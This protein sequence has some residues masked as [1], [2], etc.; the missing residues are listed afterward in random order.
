M[1]VVCLSLATQLIA[2]PT[3]P[4]ALAA[5]DYP[6]NATAR[7]HWTPQFGS[8]PVNVETQPDGST[9]L[10]LTAEFTKPGERA[11]WDWKVD[12]KLTADMRVGFEARF[13]NRAVV[14][15]NMLFFGTPHG[16]Y[17]NHGWLSGEEWQ[18]R[19]FRCDSFGTEDQPDGWEQVKTFRLSFWAAGP[20]RVVC[21]V[22][23]LWTAPADPLESLLPNGS[24]EI[25]SGGIPYGWG[26]GH[27]GVGDLPWAV[28]MELWRKHWR[29]D[30][31]V[32]KDGA[33]SL[34]LDNTAELPLLKAVSVWR[35]APKQAKQVTLSAW[36]RAESADLPVTI[37]CGQG[38]TSAMI[39]SAW[40]QVSVTTDVQG[41]RL[42]ASL[43]PQQ[44]G[45]LWVD[46]V[47]LQPGPAASADY[48]PQ[49][50][51][52]VLAQREAAVDWTP[53]QR[54]AAF[55]AGRRGSGPV[56]A[57]RASIDEHG[58]FLLDGRPYLQHSLGLEFVS[59][60]AILDFAAASGFK[61]VCLQI[62]A[63]VT[64]PELV[65][66]ADRCAKVG[67]RLIPWLDGGMT[68]EAFTA[69][70][71]ALKGHPA[72]LCWYVYDE[73]SGERFAEADAR[74]ALA[75]QLDPSRPAF[76][77]Y[78]A[79]K[80]TEQTGDIYST[81]VY[82]IPHSTPLGAIRAVA[83]MREAAV[84]EHKPVWMWLQGTGYAYWMDREPTPKEL[85]CMVY[86]SLIEGARGLYYFAQIPRSKAL[87]DELRAVLAEVDELAPALGSLDPAPPVECATPGMLV[88]SY[89]EQGAAY[90]VAVNTTAEPVEPRLMLA[91]AQGRL[92]VL[93]E[94][95]Q[96]EVDQGGWQ[97]SFAAYERHVYRL[98]AGR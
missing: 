41:E 93:F 66:L 18:Q 29:L 50:A 65:A 54:T 78:L 42:M 96:L 81:D 75:K 59:D 8:A 16:W 27:W 47:Q 44:P 24:F 98:P 46:A 91:G 84:Q 52:T 77:N 13:E 23:K 21:R 67:L 49:F 45:K 33:Q 26:S 89:R 30:P 57:A 53:P 40:Q 34:L 12:A 85:S 15:A 71:N 82:P 32:A 20:G 73:P 72:V 1:L 3:A 10:L 31:T 86:G 61:D 79:S 94:G 88:G 51:D 70:I 4:T 39:G 55:A 14:G 5:F 22:R 58:R 9:C 68:R 69:H 74:V 19:A 97:D 35:T 60:P 17:A 43:A 37:S 7:Q 11:C 48:R 38:R 80:L 56:T 64:T 63:K 6:D 36:L 92:E 90:V 28:D 95:R 76:V 83:T 62:R 25:V 87:W 2:I